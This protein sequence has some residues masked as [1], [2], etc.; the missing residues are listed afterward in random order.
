MKFIFALALIISA[1]TIGPIL[2]IAWGI[3]IW[4]V[5]WTIANW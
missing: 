5:W 2:T 4:I 3:I 1:C